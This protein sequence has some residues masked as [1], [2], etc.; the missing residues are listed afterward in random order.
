MGLPAIGSVVV[1]LFPYADLSRL[2]SRPAL[3]VGHAEF[4][5]LILCQIT[6]QKSTS[7]TAIPLT[8]KDFSSGGLLLSSYVR[9]DKLSTLED[10][11]IIDK[12][13]VLKQESLQNIL[14]KLQN[15][16]SLK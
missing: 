11:L 16:F 2:K 9:P 12:I 4:G 8:A 15:L 5:N 7:K 6:S 1:V 10:D 13:G 3:V 14:S